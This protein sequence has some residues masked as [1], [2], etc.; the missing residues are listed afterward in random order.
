METL[1]QNIYSDYCT[2]INKLKREYEVAFQA[3]HHDYRDKA[4]AAI[5]NSSVSE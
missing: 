1:P 5:Q 3:L 2:K 4:I